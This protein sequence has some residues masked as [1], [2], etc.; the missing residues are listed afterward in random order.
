MFVGD[1][2][3]CNGCLSA[4]TAIASTGGMACYHLHWCASLPVLNRSW[5]S[6]NIARPLAAPLKSTRCQPNAWLKV[7]LQLLHMSLAWLLPAQRIIPNHHDQAAHLKRI[8]ASSLL[9]GMNSDPHTRGGLQLL[10]LS[11]LSLPQMSC[12][13]CR[14]QD[15][16]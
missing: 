14:P 4:G 16:R 7:T 5:Q 15:S 10:L 9:L 6:H 1:V 12:S 3:E 13:C 2:T 11:L 8:C